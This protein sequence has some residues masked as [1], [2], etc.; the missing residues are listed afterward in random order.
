ME[1][2]KITRMLS[3]HYSLFIS[4]I[5][6]LNDEQY[7]MTANG[8]WSAGQQLHHLFLSVKPL[9]QAL[10]LPS[11]ILKFIFRKANRPS[12]TYEELVEKYKSKLAAGGRASGR[13]M[14]KPV[15]VKE[16]DM[17]IE[18]LEHAIKKLAAVINN[19]SEEDLDQILLPHP[20]LGKITLRE[21][22][23][24]TIYHAEHHLAITK[25][26]LDEIET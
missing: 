9:T 2:N 1:G 3:T 25:R 17:L 13:F 18:K 4:F 19:Y 12:K 6:T 23:Y 10:Q 16:K 20:L 21:M 5:Q 15:N 26:N 24:F 11:F 7:T 8:K 22:M 14:P